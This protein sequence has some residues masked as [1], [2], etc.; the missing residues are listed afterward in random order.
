MVVLSPYS[1]SP[2]ANFLELKTAAISSMDIDLPRKLWITVGD[3]KIIKVN[4]EKLND[5]AQILFEAMKP[6]EVSGNELKLCNIS[7]HYSI[8]YINL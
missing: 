6:Y 5:F 4:Q 7:P 2:L 1:R 8:I 3:D